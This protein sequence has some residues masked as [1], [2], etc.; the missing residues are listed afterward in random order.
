MNAGGRGGTLFEGGWIRT[1]DPER[2]H[3]TALA[4]WGERI[5]AVGETADL[6]DAFPQ[7]TRTDLTGYA[8]LLAFTEPG[9]CQRCGSW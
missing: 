9:G 1:G 5:V 8:V 6:R 4:V 2:P 7:F 3:A